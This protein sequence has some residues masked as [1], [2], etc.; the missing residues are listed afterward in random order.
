MTTQQELGVCTSRLPARSFSRLIVLNLVLAAGLG[1]IS[2]GHS[3]LSGGEVLP[4][5]ASPVLAIPS[6]AGAFAGLAEIRL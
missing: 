1:L 5:F 6:S 4:T 3:V 2:L